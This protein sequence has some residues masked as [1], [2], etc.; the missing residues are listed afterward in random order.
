MQIRDIMSQSVI[1]CS[2]SDSLNAA[3]RLM[4][5][6]DCGA[7]PVVDDGGSTVGMITDRDICMAGYIQHKLL[8]EISVTDVMSKDVATCTTSDTLEAAERLMGERQ[9][10]RLPV[11]DG[12]S[13]PVGIVSLN[14]IARYAASAHA[15]K[16]GVDRRFTETLAAI[17]EPRKSSRAAE[18]PRA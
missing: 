1:T 11:V 13:K 9:V 8:P 7:I 15:K 6:N 14:D 10:R 17:C 16:N 4:W 5:E 12:N 18:Q 3:A 2:P